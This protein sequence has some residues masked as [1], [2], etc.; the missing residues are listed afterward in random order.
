MRPRSKKHFD[1]R[2]ARV[3]PLLVSGPEQCRGQWRSVFDTG[4]DPASAQK[5]PFFDT[6]TDPASAQKALIPDTGSV[7]CSKKELHLEIGCGKGAFVSG[8]AKA[9]PDVDF[10][11]LEVVPTVI[12]MAMEKVFDD[13]V[14]AAQ[15]NVRFIVGDARELTKCFADNEIDAIY[16]NFS[17][18]WP[19]K[20]QF[21][22]RLTHEALLAEY[23]RILRP[24]G[25]IRQKTD[26]QGL[27]EFSVDG[28]RSAGFDVTVLDE[29]PAD[30]IMTEYERRFTE[31][32]LPIY[33]AV[34]VN[35][36]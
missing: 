9:R 17:D 18:P 26:N 6:G 15:Q 14:L 11:A 4:T 25:V 23:R 2:F 24:G 32:G 22:N 35:A 34:A 3:S 1:E 28:Y 33:R 27:F 19:R 7:P 20:K 16:L 10:L 30:N 29:A 36:K 31:A 13:P 8:M 12:M 5:A 21:K